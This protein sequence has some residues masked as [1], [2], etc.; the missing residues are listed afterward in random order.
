MYRMSHPCIDN[1]PVHE[2]GKDHRYMYK[3]GIVNT[4]TWRSWRRIIVSD[5]P[6]IIQG[7]L[8]KS[9]AQRS[10]SLQGKDM[11]MLSRKD[12]GMPGEI[13]FTGRCRDLWLKEMPKI[14][15]PLMAN[16]ADF[17]MGTR[18]KGILKKILCRGF[19]VHRKSNIDQHL[20]ELF[21]TP[22]AMLT[23]VWGLYKGSIW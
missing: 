13:Y 11:G 1:Y 17:V 3:E 15:K 18:I 23:V 22:W 21:N 5:I 2:R 19:T 4:C 12:S 8:Q 6:R 10:L 20:N 9:L 7:I 14:I 16:E